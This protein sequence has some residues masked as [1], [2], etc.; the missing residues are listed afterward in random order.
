M[1]S[2]FATIKW[3]INLIFEIEQRQLNNTVIE[4]NSAQCVHQKVGAL[5]FK[6]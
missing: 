3:M 4:I 6:T 5:R 1:Y 2:C